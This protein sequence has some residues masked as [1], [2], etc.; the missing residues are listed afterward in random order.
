MK[1]LVLLLFALG[2]LTFQFGCTTTRYMSFQQASEPKYS[3]DHLVLHTP[4]TT[5]DL[6]NYRF[7]DEMLQGSLK[8]IADKKKSGVHV[9]TYMNFEFSSVQDSI[10]QI[11]IPKSNIETV[12]NRSFSLSKTILLIWICGAPIYAASMVLIYGL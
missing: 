4:K 5:Y 2:I 11:S 7:T 10:L 9:F 8:Q 12:M 3:R 1:K 6:Y